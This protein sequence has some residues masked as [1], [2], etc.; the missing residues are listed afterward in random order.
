MAKRDSIFGQM[1]QSEDLSSLTGYDERS[2]K[3][4]ESVETRPIDQTFSSFKPSDRQYSYSQD[5]AAQPY[6]PQAAP[7]YSP[8][9]SPTPLYGGQDAARPYYEQSGETPMV[10]ALRS[11][12]GSYVYEYADRLEIY[13][14]SLYSGMKLEK[15]IL[16]KR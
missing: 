7:A 1:G 12:P 14:H 11:E 10:F 9:T 2:V 4:I 13:R 5:G 6:A 8:A 3:P 15:T 16:K